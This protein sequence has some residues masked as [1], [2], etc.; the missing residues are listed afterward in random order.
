MT[1]TFLLIRHGAHGD[2]DT[3]LS[4]RRAGVP[5][6]EDGRA[7][8]ARLGAYIRAEPVT[9]VQ[10]SPLD[11]TRE[12]AA[13]LAEALALPAPET[14]DALLEIDFGAL[15]GR[16]F[17]S[18]HGDPVWDEWN[19]SRAAAQ[20]PGG[21]RMPDVVERVAAHLQATVAA[22]PGELIALVTHADIVKA[23]VVWVLGLDLQKMHAF[24]IGPASVTRMVVGDWG[25]RV[26][27][28]NESARG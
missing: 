23:A 9:R 25:G 14:V 5:L 15:T 13:I 28:L 19:N 2:L 17:D 22:H 20:L 6:R 24:D 21:E 4:G 7:Q 26:L 10:C 16:S 27:S 18:L 8:A 3:V 1:A 11:R 12:T